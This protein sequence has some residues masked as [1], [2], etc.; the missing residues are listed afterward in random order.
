MITDGKVSDVKVAHTLRVEPG[1]I[2]VDNRGYNDYPLFAKWTAPLVLRLAR[3]QLP[4]KIIG[5]SN[6]F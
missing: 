5:Q 2:V 3:L 1:T 6:G 4:I